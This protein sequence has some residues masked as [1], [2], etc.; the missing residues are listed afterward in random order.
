MTCLHEKRFETPIREDT[1]LFY[2]KATSQRTPQHQPPTLKPCPPSSS[3]P[4]SWPR[5]PPSPPPAW[6]PPSAPPPPPS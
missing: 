6:T 2:D 3:V 5:L 4:P 1:S